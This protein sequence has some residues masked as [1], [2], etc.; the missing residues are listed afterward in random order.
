MVRKE[1]HRAD[2][3]PDALSRPPVRPRLDAVA[4]KDGRDHAERQDVEA[5]AALLAK[6]EQARAALPMPE[7]ADV[8]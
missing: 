5:V 4:W 6:L 7:R 1:L 2:H 8:A 3:M